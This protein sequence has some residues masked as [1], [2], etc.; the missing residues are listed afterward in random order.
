MAGHGS[1]AEE[2]RVQVHTGKSAI[3]CTHRANLRAGAQGLQFG[4]AREIQPAKY[5][6]PSSRTGDEIICGM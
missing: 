3:L 6:V 4:A 2:G 5:D 1:G